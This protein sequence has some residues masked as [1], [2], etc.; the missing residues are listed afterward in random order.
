MQ[1][2]PSKNTGTDKIPARFV[3]DAA[4]VFKNH[5]GHIINLLIE[6]MWFQKI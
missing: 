2:N 6:K 1:I 3:K 5:I 4:S